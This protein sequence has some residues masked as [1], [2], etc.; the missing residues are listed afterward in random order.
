M[1]KFLKFAIILLIVSIITVVVAFVFQN[2]HS[3]TQSMNFSL[4]LFFIRFQSRDLPVFSLIFGAFIS[5]LLISILYFAWDHLKHSWKMRSK[6]K[7]IRQLEKEVDK[8]RN[9]PLFEMESSNSVKQLNPQLAS[10]IE[11]G[12]DQ[13]K[14]SSAGFGT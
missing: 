14:D 7:Q 11:S 12:S 6:D 2:S 5:G 9:I 1:I 3:M 10:D 13:T 4:N 8:L